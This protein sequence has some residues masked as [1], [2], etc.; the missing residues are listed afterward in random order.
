MQ[1]QWFPGHMHKA[2]VQIEALLPNVDLFIEVLDARI[3]YSS[4]NPL[5]RE[6]RGDKPGLKIL[7]KSDLADPAQTRNWQEH[8]EQNRTIRARAVSAK[9]AGTIRKLTTVCRELVTGSKPVLNA[10]IVGVPNVGKST[11]INILAGRKIAKTGNEP[12]VTR[13]QQK[14]RIG[15]G[16]YLYDTPGMLWPNVENPESGYRLAATGAIKDTA[17]DYA[18]IGFFAA[19]F[20]LNNYPE[21]L[22]AR[23]ELDELPTDTMGFM[24]EIGRKKGCLRKGG[25][26]DLD[27]ISRIFLTELRSGLCGRVTFETP[28]MAEAEIA[29]VIAKREEKAERAKSEGITRKQRRKRKRR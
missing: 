2:R 23:F 28:A 19:E 26:V 17:I 5:L 15:D 24:E 10:M 6:L 7:N 8:L 29:R 18:D 14:V 22:A 11:V 27:R 12:A 16:L 13:G 4:E 3:P 1:I 9:E 25:I 21:G 20:M